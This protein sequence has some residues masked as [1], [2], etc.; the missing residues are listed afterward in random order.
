MS[1]T[2]TGRPTPFTYLPHLDTASHRISRLSSAD[3]FEQTT[4]PTSVCQLI[5][6][7][8]LAT[9]AKLPYLERI[10]LGI[11]CSYEHNTA[12]LRASAARRSILDFAMIRSKTCS[13]PL[14]IGQECKSLKFHVIVVASIFLTYS[15]P[16]LRR[17]VTYMKIQ[18]VSVSASHEVRHGKNGNFRSSPN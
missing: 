1:C 8:H 18:N 3:I 15:L 2:W 4:Y 10:L 12:I 9:S 17:F 16:A 6:C 13:L 11:L 14:C 7:V 5:I